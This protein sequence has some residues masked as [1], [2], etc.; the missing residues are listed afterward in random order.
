MTK[1]RF[2]E[3]YFALAAAITATAIIGLVKHNKLA[4]ILVG[5]GVAQMVI[6]IITWRREKHSN[7]LNH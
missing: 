3:I 2:A 7:K 1:K 4:W 6:A 5:I